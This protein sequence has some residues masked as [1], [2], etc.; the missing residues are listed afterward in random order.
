MRRP[1]SIFT[2]HHIKRKYSRVHESW[3]IVS[4]YHIDPKSFSG[5]RWSPPSFPEGRDLRSMRMPSCFTGT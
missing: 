3:C 1:A 5:S 4:G 2:A